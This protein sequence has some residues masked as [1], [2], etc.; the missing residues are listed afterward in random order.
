VCARFLK[1]LLGG[2]SD[3]Q[4]GVDQIREWRQWLQN[5]VAYVHK[6]RL[7][8][9]LGLT[10][11]NS[12]FEALVLV[13]RRVKMPQN[14]KDAARYEWRENLNNHVHTYD[15]VLDR[16]RAAIRFQDTP[17]SNPYLIPRADSAEIIHG[18]KR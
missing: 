3:T 6:S 4:K 13:G 17:A 5:K 15:W 8:D 11:M 18:R 14:T 10:D 1:L 2:D 16:L 12:L 7:K 9:G